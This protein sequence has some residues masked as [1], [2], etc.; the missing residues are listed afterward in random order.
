MEEDVVVHLYHMENNK[1]SINFKTYSD[2]KSNK[3]NWLDLVYGSSG[4]KDVL[5]YYN[6]EYKCSESG[7]IDYKDLVDV[8]EKKQEV[9]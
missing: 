3:I 8:L 5:D 4:K 1:L 9:L 2:L 7:S 6:C